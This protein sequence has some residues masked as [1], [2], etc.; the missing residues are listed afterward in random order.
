DEKNCRLSSTCSLGVD[1]SALCAGGFG[2]HS[3]N[4]CPSELR[5]NFVQLCHIGHP[6]SA[7][8][9]GLRRYDQRKHRL[10]LDSPTKLCGRWTNCLY[11]LLYD[12]SYLHDIDWD[13]AF[14]RIG[15]QQLDI[16]AD[17]FGT[18]TSID[19]TTVPGTSG[20]VDIVN[21]AITHANAGSPVVGDGMRLKLTRDAVSDDA[22][23]DGEI[24]FVEIKE[25]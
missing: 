19:N 11:P 6:K 14:E 10:L 4:S 13:V 5:T 20:L 7:P 24:R 2:R 18:V 3:Y 17:N 9:F 16:D 23:D 22:A 21:G 25:T 15:D 12:D 8:R 1:A